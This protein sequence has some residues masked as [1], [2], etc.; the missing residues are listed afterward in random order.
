[1]DQAAITAAVRRGIREPL[2]RTVSDSQIEA[3]TLRGVLVV[4]MEIKRVDPSFFYTRKVLTSNT[5]IFPYPSNCTTVLKV[6]DLKTNA[7]V[8]TGAADN[9]A[10][11]VRITSVDHGLASNDIVPITDVL[12]T[13]EANDTWKITVITDDTFDLVGSVFANAYVS[14]GLA[15][16]EPHRFYEINKVN[17]DEATNKDSEQWYPRSRNVVI[18]NPDYTDDILLN[19]DSAPDA[20][21]DIPAEYH[22]YLVSFGVV[23]LMRIPTP[24]NPEYSDKVSSLGYHHRMIDRITDQ[25]NATLKAS[26]EPEHFPEEIDF[27]AFM[28]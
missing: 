20:I 23:D 19:Y 24:D 10:G 8:I 27:D 26:S 12:G 11:L 3:V 1:M 9:G 13:T 4:G 2:V 18:D 17:L 25:I 6:W 16:K 5:H 7:I 28:N 21:T 22:E 15:Y 14:G